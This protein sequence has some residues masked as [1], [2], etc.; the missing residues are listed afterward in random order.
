M[1]Q[2][3]IE[4]SVLYHIMIG[5]IICYVTLYERAREQHVVPSCPR[6]QEKGARGDGGG[7]GGR[8]EAELHKV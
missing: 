6:V 8:T 5:H 1:E 2:K 7:M 4:S 3:V